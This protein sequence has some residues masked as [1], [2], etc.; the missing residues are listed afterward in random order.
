MEQCSALY[1]K[2][3]DN[4]SPGKQISRSYSREWHSLSLRRHLPSRY[5]FCRSI[6]AQSKYCTLKLQK[7]L[8]CVINNLIHQLL[9]VCF[10][11]NF[12]NF[13]LSRSVTVTVSVT[14]PSFFFFFLSLFFIPTLLSWLLFSWLI[15]LLFLCRSSYVPPRPHLIRFF[16]LCLTLFLW[17]FFF[18]PPSHFH[19]LAPTESTKAQCSRCLQS[20]WLLYIQPANMFAR[21]KSVHKVHCLLELSNTN[22]WP[23]GVWALLQLCKPCIWGVAL[24]ARNKRKQEFNLFSSLSWQ[25][26]DF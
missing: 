14:S 15:R 24:F 3:A 25:Y 4:W 9:V 11:S 23:A 2:S 22:Y 20:I 1:S 18:F 13:L 5:H 26:E 7:A 12:W 6:I 8:K 21:T 19:Y 16:P 10:H 17:S